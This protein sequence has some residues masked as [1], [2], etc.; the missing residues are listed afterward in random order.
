MQTY[1]QR[2]RELLARAG[3]RGVRGGGG[4]MADAWRNP[5]PDTIGGVV[6]EN[7]VPAIA[8]VGLGAFDASEYGQAFERYIH[9]VARPSTV[10][11]V[12]GVG[13]R[14]ANWDKNPKLRHANNV[15][16]RT[17]FPV[18]GYRLGERLVGGSLFAGVKK[19]MSSAKPAA[20][21]AVKPA[22]AK[23]A[24]AGVGAEA[25]VPGERTAT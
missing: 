2:A 12:L 8:G 3:A 24:T 21:P 25:P 20:K 5:R 7:A 18:L 19:M 14:A 6:S 15:L 22:P 9:D 23:P 17:M 13:L 16:L 1:Q 4:A 11:F 10:A